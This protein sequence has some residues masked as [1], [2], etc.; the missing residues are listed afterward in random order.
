M[1]KFYVFVYYQPLRDL[2]LET[3]PIES[4]LHKVRDALTSGSLFPLLGECGYEYGG[5]IL[6]LPPQV[7]A[8]LRDTQR[9]RA[10]TTAVDGSDLIL[11]AT[12][13]PL[14]DR[15]EEVEFQ[16]KRRLVASGHDLEKNLFRSLRGV[17]SKCD[18]ETIRL[19]AARFHRAR[20]SGCAN[21]IS[22]NQRV[23][24][25]VTLRLRGGGSHRR[26]GT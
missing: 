7:V 16:G 17:F 24:P 20:T 5:T 8:E 22:I 11:L 19:A 2:R 4:Q 15:P 10:T 25:S 18:R 6:N 14:D 26:E 3:R 1:A 9:L 12:R 13:P 23:G 21:C